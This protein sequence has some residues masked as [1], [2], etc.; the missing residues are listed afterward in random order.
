MA[1]T[2]YWI[3]KVD[4][5]KVKFATSEANAIAGT[6]IDITSAAGGGTHTIEVQ[7]FEDFSADNATQ[8]KD[9]FISYIDVLARATTESFTAVFT[10]SRNLIVRVRDGGATPIKTFE[11]TSAQ[12][13]STAQTVAATRTS[14]A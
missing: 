11:A 3:I 2:D 5:N 10:T 6:D 7:D 9:V 1:P 14:D 13:L 8:P 4:A 12:F